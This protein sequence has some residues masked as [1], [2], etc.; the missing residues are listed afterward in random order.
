MPNMGYLPNSLPGD[1]GVGWVKST[2]A[3]SGRLKD[4]IKEL[5]RATGKRIKKKVINSKPKVKIKTKGSDTT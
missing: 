5:T 4:P 3:V 1:V 2:P